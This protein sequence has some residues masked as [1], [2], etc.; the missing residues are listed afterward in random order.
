[1]SWVAAQKI[2][3]AGVER[4]PQ[5][6]ENEYTLHLGVDESSFCESENEVSVVTQI[7]HHRVLKVVRDRRFPPAIGSSFK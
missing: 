3:T 1:M 2:M 5:E 4:G 6:R 7:D